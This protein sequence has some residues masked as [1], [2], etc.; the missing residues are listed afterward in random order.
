MAVVVLFPALAGDSR[1]LAPQTPY[2]PPSMTDRWNWYV[3]DTFGPGAALR[4]GFVAAMDHAD[5]DPPEWEQG[6]AGFG[7]RAASRYG[8]FA[9]Q[10]TIELGGGA[11]LG[12]DPRYHP[13]KCSGFFRRSGHALVSTVVARNANGKPT[14]A[15]ARIAGVY[16]GSMLATHLWYPSRF[17]AAGDG[18][19][20]GNI[21]LGVS[22]GVNL[23]REFWPDIK[24]VFRRD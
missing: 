19:R 7:R 9:L 6:M 3:R 18:F 8:R 22:G 20:L 10:E 12:E 15:F 14:P 2:Q 23:V 1:S 21:S 4:T 17:T 13:C 16:G 5:N 11:L 24:R